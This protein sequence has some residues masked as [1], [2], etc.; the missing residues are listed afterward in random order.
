MNI[1]DK[2]RFLN[3]TGGGKVTGFRGK[4]IVL[5]EDETGFEI[6]CM[7]NEVVAVETDQYNFVHKSRKSTTKEVAP[8]E[9]QDAKPTSL[10]AALAAHSQQQDDDAEEETDIADLK[11]TF[12]ARPVERRGGDELNLYLGFLPAD[13]K[14]LTT[15]RFEAYFINDSN[16]Y[17]RFLLLTQEGTTYRLRQE[18]LAEPNMKVYLETFD[19]DALP[20]IERL[21]VVVMA[22]KTDRGFQLKQP[23]TITVRLDGRKF[24]KLHTFQPSAFFE[25][26]AYICELVRDDHPA[27]QVALEADSLREAMET[28][29]VAPK[30]QPARSEGTLPGFRGTDRNGLIEVDLHIENLV[31]NTRGMDARAMLDHQ[32]DTVARYLDAHSKERGRRIVFIHGKG[33]GILRNAIIALLKKKY[34]NCTHQDASFQEYGFGA[35]MVTIH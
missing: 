29:K 24:Y 22:Y 35:T 30:T 4:D 10:R 34:R 31:D 16:Y 19:R 17:V 27:R 5:V 1:G 13:V 7:V 6:P 32:L 11:M 21:T 20:E 8:P 12:H 25:D 28:P 18:G 9:L 2:V 33:D 15:T 14:T 26:A 23:M 3:A